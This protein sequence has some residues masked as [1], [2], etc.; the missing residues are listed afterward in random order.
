MR[1]PG[2]TGAGSRS[3]IVEERDIHIDRPINRTLEIALVLGSLI[4]QEREGVL[5][6]P[7]PQ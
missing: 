5:A 1:F 4:P 7:Q 3:E 2:R 6:C